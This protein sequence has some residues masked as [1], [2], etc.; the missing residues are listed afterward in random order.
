MVV[1]LPPEMKL[2]GVPELPG[3]R[4]ALRMLEVPGTPVRQEKSALPDPLGLGPL[5]T[6]DPVVLLATPDPVVLPATPDH[7]EVQELADP[8]AHLEVAEQRLT[9]AWELWVQL[10]VLITSDMDAFPAQRH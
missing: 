8:Q 7:L 6:P 5:A 4:Q 2:P 10:S 9:P 1:T 3:L